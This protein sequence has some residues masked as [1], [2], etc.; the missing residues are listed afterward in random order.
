MTDI[1]V[2][3][4]ISSILGDEI[5][6]LYRP[7]DIL[8]SETDLAKRF[9]VNRHTVRRAISELV[10]L[11]RVGTLQGKGTIVQQKVIN[12]SIHST[13]RFT[14]TLENCG[15]QPESLVLKKSGIPAHR[16]VAEMLEIEEGRPVILV[17][18]LRKMDGAPFSVV[19]HFLPLDKVFEVMR[20]YH[21]G[22]LHDFLLR[23]YGIRLRRKISLISAVAP[24][25][26]DIE[27]LEI[28]GNHPLL[29]V[30]SVNIDQ[31]T[32]EPLELSISRFKGISTQ[33]SVEPAWISLE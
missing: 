21:G 11:G 12:Y 31:T 14:K 25:Q 30:K 15:R 26:Y 27:H 10:T 23:Q 2:F 17:E 28:T 24:N 29:K 22:S 4:Q 1:P 7:G 8:P 18:T 20:A 33:L 6:K 9:K 13:T 32:G 3:K 19:S 5:K 16:E